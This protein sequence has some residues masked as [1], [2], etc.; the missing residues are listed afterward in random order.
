MSR[1]VFLQKK[2]KLK[3]KLNNNKFQWKKIGNL[4]QSIIQC[5]STIK[6]VWWSK[7]KKKSQRPKYD[8]MNDQSQL[9]FRVGLVCSN[10]FSGHQN[11]E[12][13]NQNRQYVS[14][15]IWLCDGHSFI[16]SI[17]LNWNKFPATT[18][19]ANFRLDQ[20]EII[21]TENQYNYTIDDIVRDTENKNNVIK[22]KIIMIMIIMIIVII[23]NQIWRTY[24]IHSFIHSVF[25][26]I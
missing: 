8:W 15:W 18:A 20:V 11:R 22:R 23:R 4:N 9:K 13:N 3:L 10:F 12:K 6:L 14:M 19:R 16:Y 7:Q 25:C 26:W 2:T 24:F 21:E 17:S 5:I 1:I